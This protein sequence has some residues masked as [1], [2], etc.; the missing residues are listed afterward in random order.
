MKKYKK[1]RNILVYN[2]SYETLMGAK[3]L[4]ISFDKMNG[5]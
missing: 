4:H 3:P 5:F 1:Y 2:S